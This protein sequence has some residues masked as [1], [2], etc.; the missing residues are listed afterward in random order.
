MKEFKI[1]IPQGYEIDIEHST[2]ECIKFKKKEERNFIVPTTYIDL[3]LPSGTLWAD[4]NVRASLCTDNGDYFTWE[5][6]QQFELPTKEQFRELIDNCKWEWRENLKGC[7][8]IGKNGTSIFLPA[9]GYRHWRIDDKV[10]KTKE[11]FLAALADFSP[12]VFP[13]KLK[14]ITKEL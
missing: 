13:L 14:H 5:K 12:N 6:A 11:K 2:F 8:V 9:A 1:T 4:K 7:D 10:Y 3:G